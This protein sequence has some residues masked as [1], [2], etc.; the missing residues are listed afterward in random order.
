M[1]STLTVLFAIISFNLCFA[2][3]AKQFYSTGVKF[4]ENDDMV[5]AIAQFDQCIALTPNNINAYIN[6]AAAY[7]KTNQLQ[8]ALDD[9]RIVKSLKSKETGFYYDA[10]RICYTLG[11]HDEGLTYIPAVLEVK[12]KKFDGYLLQIKLFM[13]KGDYPQAITA[14]NMAIAINDIPQLHFYKGQSFEKTDDLINAEKEYNTAIVQKTNYIDALNALA[15]LQIRLNK[16]DQA[17]ATTNK[18]IACDDKNRE[19]FLLRSK[20]YIQK[21]N[22]PDAINDLSRII[23]LNPDDKELFFTRGTYYQDFTQHQ[24][25]INDFNKV[26]LLDDK[27]AEA[28]YKRAYSYEQIANYNQAIKD[29][30]KLIELSVDDANAKNRLALAQ[31]RLFELNRESKKPQVVITEPTP[32]NDGSV[33]IAKNLNETTIKGIILDDSDIKAITLNNVNVSFAR[34]NNSLVFKAQ[35]STMGIDSFAVAATDVYDNTQMV[36]YK[37]KRTEINPPV[38]NLISPYASDNGEIFLDS[39]TPTLYIEG[40]IS[41]ESRINSI[42]IDGVLASFKLDDINPRFIATI[43][44]TNKN[45]FTVSAKDIY[46]NQT[47]KKYNINRSG[48][49][50]LEKN[51]MGRTWV[52]FLENSNYQNFPSL[53]GPSRDVTLMRSALAGY[54]VHNI[55][56][57]RNLSKSQME[58]FFSIELRDLIRANGVRSV[59]IWYAGHG[60]FLNE[61]GYWIPTDANRDDEFSY[62]SINSLKASM[63]GYN[64]ILAHTLLVTDACESGP[65]F[66]QAMRGNIV[67]RSC[68]DWEASKLKS[69]QVLTSAGYELA[70]DNSQF[71]KTF[72][73]ML[74]NN[75]NTCI[76]IESIVLKVT[77]AV[78]QSQQQ[79]P[80]FGKISGLSDE[81]GTFFFM[82][83]KK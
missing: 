41:D 53:D 23:M 43:Q 30:N 10:A 28:Y 68:G 2:Q 46:G 26:I 7:E 9:Y 67:E 75:P 64:N 20:V 39:D 72:A 38:I 5:N 1:R 29:Y 52:V 44:I 78:E 17:L 11:L 79:K 22:Y 24:N 19:A 16:P 62:Y 56:H 73:N 63:Q 80:K 6:R 74:T 70:L 42:F 81:D 54:D 76:P 60:K 18:T 65:T 37:L 4:L 8:K 61:T 3:N 34:E 66:Y 69:S 35:F 14:A 51:P 58:R 47:D 27:N 57:K 83:K 32:N 50:L 40:S 33:N 12:K 59:L 71:T 55:I 36:A 21:L 48:I 25:A 31:Q 77:Q 15:S 49:S 82:N 13:A 45:S